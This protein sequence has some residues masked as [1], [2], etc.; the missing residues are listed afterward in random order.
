MS[1]ALQLKTT[2]FHK[3][4]T[5]SNRYTR[6][7]RGLE[8]LIP[9]LIK[10]R[11]DIATEVGLDRTRKLADEI[12]NTT[13]RLAV[14]VTSVRRLYMIACRLDVVA[15]IS[16][17]ADDANVVVTGDIELVNLALAVGNVAHLAGE[18]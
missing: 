12:S 11:P 13:R 10:C 7:R 17:G 18:R 8:I 14:E 3:N 16:L 6:R 15:I 2:W 9:T 4:S 5:P 1:L